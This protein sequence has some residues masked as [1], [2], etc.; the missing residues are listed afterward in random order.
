MYLHLY[1][2]FWYITQSKMSF[3]TIDHINLNRPSD[4]CINRFKQIR[5]NVTIWVILFIPQI[6]VL[7][8]TSQCVG[9]SSVHQIFLPLSFLLCSIQYSVVLYLYT[10]NS[11]AIKK[12]LWFQRVI[13]NYYSK[14]CINRNCHQQETRIFNILQAYTDGYVT[15]GA[16]SML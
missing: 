2:I 1:T 8:Q 7:C 12:I 11:T 4:T 3:H 16:R 13:Y 6:S 5:H 15:C 10:I 14:T 9:P